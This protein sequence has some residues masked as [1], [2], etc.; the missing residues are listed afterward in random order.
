MAK[1]WVHLPTYSAFRKNVVVYDGPSQL[2]G[3][4]IYVVA[5]ARNANRKIGRMIQFWVLPA[6]SP[7]R[8]IATGADRMVCGDC[9]LRGD[10]TGRRR[11]CY[12]WTPGL[13]V[14]HKH[15]PNAD[16]MTPREFAERYPKRRLRLAAY[17]DPLAAP[18]PFWD[19]L[20][21]TADGWTAYTH[22][23]Q[24]PDAAEYRSFCMASVNDVDEQRRA[25]AAGWRTFR[26]RVPG[27]GLLDGEIVCPFESGRT[28]CGRCELCKG[29]S[30]RAKNVVVDVHGGS[31]RF[32]PEVI[33]IGRRPVEAVSLT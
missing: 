1:T 3:E 18:K 17:G 14:I 16:R 28:V 6:I 21:S 11:V 26:A 22:Q 15:I 8:A 31:K 19:E 27:T 32:Y 7:L 12:V 20:R 30:L 4:R 23:W 2:T 13:E 10:G 5:S 9:A 33:Q 29:S 24:R 25:A